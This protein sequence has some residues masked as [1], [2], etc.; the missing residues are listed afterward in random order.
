[1]RRFNPEM[2]T[3]AR[4]AVGLTQS[5][6][7]Q[8]LQI[9]QGTLSKIENGISDPDDE[10]VEMCATLLGVT[11][12]YFYRAEPRRGNPV[13]FYRKRKGM[14]QRDIRHLEAKLQMLRLDVGRLMRAVHVT[15]VFELPHIKPTSKGGP[16]EVARQVRSTWSLPTGPIVNLIGVLEA[17]GIIVIGISWDHKF[18]AMSVPALD[19][20]PPIIFYNTSMPPDRRRFTLAHELGHLVMHM[21]PTDEME[22]E[23]DL[24]AAEFLVPFAEVKHALKGL[25]KSNLSA[26]KR[27]W[28]VSMTSIVYIAQNHEMI[29]Y[30]QARYFFSFLK[31]NPYANERITIPEETPT[32]FRELIEFHFNELGYSQQELAASVMLPCDVFL[33]RYGLER[34]GSHLKLV[35]DASHVPR[36]N[37]EQVLSN[38][39]EMQFVCL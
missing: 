3:L 21:V 20:I 22:E 25:K 12:S 14:G 13:S 18:D 9:T 30:N 2:L 19:G 35:H 26:L 29:T 32:L 37:Q 24:F 15:G 16:S 1:M 31:R 5:A 36:P 11:T 27:Q 38:D 23:A 39:V 8:N 6:L 7:A 28:R 4:E 10:V 33:K 17:V 34:K